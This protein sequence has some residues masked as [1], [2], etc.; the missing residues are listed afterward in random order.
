MNIGYR[1]RVRRQQ[2]GLSLRDLAARSGLSVS[3]VSQVERD[4]T[5]PSISSLKQMADA[6]DV[7]VAALLADTTPGHTRVLRRHERPSAE[8]SRIRYELLATGE[9]R[10]MEPQLVTFEPGADSGSHPVTHEGEEFG[11]I[12]SGRAE[13]WIGE[14]LMVLEEGDCVYFD[15]TVPHRM[16]NSGSEPCVWLHVVT[17]ASF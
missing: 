9:G 10:Q 15:A 1:L 11:M 17:P 6:L 2:M 13:C 7:Q 12:L 3:F 5:R 4:I 16:R 8:L 14:D